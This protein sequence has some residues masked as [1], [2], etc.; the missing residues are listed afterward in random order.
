MIIR[1][2]HAIRPWQHV[3][4]PLSGYLELAQKLYEHGI[5]FAEG[6]NFGP[7]DEDAR[8]VEWIVSRLTRQWGEDAGWQID[9]SSHHLHEAHYLKLDCSKAKMRLD[10]LPRWSL[11]RALDSIIAWQRAYLMQQDMRK[12]TVQQIEQFTHGKTGS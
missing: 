12:V 1:S 5:S 7:S 6:W 4:E 10:W 3:L 8:P 11:P 9:Q 2:P